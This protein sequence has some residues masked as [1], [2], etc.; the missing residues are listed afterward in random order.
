MNERKF[1]QTDVFSLEEGDNYFRRNVSAL[2]HSRANDHVM[3]ALSQWKDFEVHSV[4]ELGCANGWRLALITEHLSSIERCAGRDVSAE[5]IGDGRKRWPGLELGV[6]SLDEPNLEGP[7]DV[8]IVSY[9]FHWVA[10]DRLA[11]SVSAVDHLV[12]DGGALI[13]ADFLPDSPC[14]RIYHHRSDVEIYTYKQDYS[15]CFKSLELYA[16]LHSQVFAHSDWTDGVPDA[17]DRAF[18]SLL[19]KNLGGYQKL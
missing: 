7:F 18:C 6:G 14:K 3:T 9:V 5:A 13:L 4:C 11:A 1:D 8:V 12:R 2:D 17:Q 16:E 15:T 19:R 10:R